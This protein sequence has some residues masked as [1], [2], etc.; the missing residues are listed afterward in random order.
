MEIYRFYKKDIT[1]YKQIQYLNSY[2]FVLNL[3]RNNSKV[4]LFITGDLSTKKQLVTELKYNISYEPQNI[5]KE[6]PKKNQLSS[7]NESKELSPIGVTRLSTRENKKE[8]PIK[9]LYNYF[10]NSP[11]VRKT[12]NYIKNNNLSKICINKY[13]NSNEVISASNIVQPNLFTIKENT[14]EDSSRFN[15]YQKQYTSLPVPI[16]R[17]PSFNSP[18][19]CKYS[20]LQF[21]DISS[22]NKNME[23]FTEYKDVVVRRDDKYTICMCSL[24]VLAISYFFSFK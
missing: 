16:K 18:T 1:K 3:D 22:D 19:D 6:T 4:P 14:I 17:R 11:Y 23:F 15:H 9:R 20:K 2:S 12:V 24:V 5:R 21:S 8:S 10:R 7:Q 13:K